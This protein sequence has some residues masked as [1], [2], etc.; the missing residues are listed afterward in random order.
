MVYSEND[1]HEIALWESLF[2]TIQLGEMEIYTFAS[3]SACLH[4]SKY[5]EIALRISAN[6]LASHLNLKNDSFPY[7][8]IDTFPT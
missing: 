2:Q 3:Q 4:V 6:E 8:E 7:Y 5:S 1:K